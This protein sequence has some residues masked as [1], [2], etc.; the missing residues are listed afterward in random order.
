LLASMKDDAGR[1]VI[2]GF[3]DGIPKLTPDEMRIQESVPDDLDELKRFFGIAQPDA[4]GRNLQDALQYPSLNVRGLRSAYVGEEARTIIPSDATAAIDVRLVKETPS[5]PMIEKIMAHIRKQGFH[6]VESEPD[7]P[8]RSKYSKFVRVSRR[9]STEA[10]RTDMDLPISMAVT[11]AIER[12]WGK[13]PVRIRTMGGTV[14]I[15]QFIRV[16]KFPAIGVPIVNF[17]NNQH[18]ENENLKLENLWKGIVTLAALLT[19][20]AG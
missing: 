5:G 17:D 14:P 18:S 16:L 13:E 4:G 20:E 19:L 8:T 3:Y 1:V 10:Y 2:A 6:I 15:S 12:T 7:D 11:Q 9:Q